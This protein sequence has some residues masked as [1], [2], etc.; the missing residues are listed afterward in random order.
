MEQLSQ[1]MFCDT[2][3]NHHT[4]IPLPFVRVVPDRRQWVL[5]LV[6]NLILPRQ[7]TLEPSCLPHPQSDCVETQ[8][9]LY[10]TRPTRAQLE[11]HVLLLETAWALPRRYTNMGSATPRTAGCRQDSTMTSD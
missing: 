10:N 5:Q 7:P 11:H 8:S 4:L 3:L 2:L 9:L 1:G 6:P